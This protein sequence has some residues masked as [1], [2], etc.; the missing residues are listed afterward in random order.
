MKFECKFDSHYYCLLIKYKWG[1]SSVGRALE[2]HSRGRRFDPVRLHICG[3]FN[4]WND[5]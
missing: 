3:V 1:R 4:L 5:C 2:W